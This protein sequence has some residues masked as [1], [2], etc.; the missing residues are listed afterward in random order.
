[1]IS[2]SLKTIRL[3]FLLVSFWYTDFRLATRKYAGLHTNA[4]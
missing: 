1:M 4:L 2:D 3:T